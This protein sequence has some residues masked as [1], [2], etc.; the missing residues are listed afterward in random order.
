MKYNF[1]FISIYVVISLLLLTS[2]SV[3]IGES[4]NNYNLKIDIKPDNTLWRGTLRN[5][6]FGFF[7]FAR[8]G[9]GSNCFIID[10][11]NDGPE[12]CEDFTVEIEYIWLFFATQMFDNNW[13]QVREYFTV[14]G[15][16][17]QSGDS[18][19]LLWNYSYVLHGLYLIKAKIISDDN[20]LNDNSAY[21]LLRVVHNAYT[22]K[23]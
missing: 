21:C 5:K 13:G 22:I 14:E 17:L 16:Q 12:D 15:T 10:V 3:I 2:F 6:L 23:P 7:G 9:Q 8:T 11:T 18:I 20:Y 1:K 4:N 19:Q